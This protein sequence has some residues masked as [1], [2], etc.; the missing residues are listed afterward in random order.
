MKLAIIGSYGHVNVVTEG[1]GQC[2]DVELVA[3]ARWGPEDSLAAIGKAVPQTLPVYDDCRVMLDKHRPE[4]AAVFMPLYRLAE[5]SLEAA[6]R[7]C[8]VISEKPLATSL[9][10]LSRLR[11]AAERAGVRLCALMTARGEGAFAA[12][13]QA[14]RDGRIGR[15]ISATAQKSYPFGTRDDFYRSRSTYGGTIPWQVIHAIDYI[16]FCTGLDYVRVA[17][18][19]SNA[20]HPSHAGMEDQG[21]L[22][23][24]LTGGGSAIIN[25]DYLRPWGAAGRKWGDDRLRIAGS[26]GIIET[27]DC[28][29]AVELLTPQASELLPPLRR[30]NVFVNFVRALVGA[31]EPLISPAESFRM[32]EVALK[33]RQ[34]Q[35]SGQWVRI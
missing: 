16:H 31:Q 26:G 18:T 11:Q 2:P 4:V 1:L 29:T 30:R 3:L 13:R 5:A 28:A 17:A 10:D 9:E 24:E 22:L 34:A 8:H 33:A 25:F 21:G 19:A 27:K 32:T 12:I 35:D 15:C 6:G 14:V 23:A 20:A 7:G